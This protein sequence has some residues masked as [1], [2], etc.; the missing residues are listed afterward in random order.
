MSEPTTAAEFVRWFRAAFQRKPMCIQEQLNQEI[1]RLLDQDILDT[2]DYPS[3][4]EK[5]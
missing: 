1:K 2:D 3:L 4:Q 5:R